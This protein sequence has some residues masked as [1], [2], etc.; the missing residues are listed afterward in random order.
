MRSI[1]VLAITIGIL[2]PAPAAELTAVLRQQHIG[3][4]VQKLD[5]PASLPK[6][7]TSGLTNRLLLR[8]S[9]RRDAQ[10]LEETAIEIA[11]RFDL[12]DEVFHVATT[13]AA[14]ESRRV[15]PSLEATLRALEDLQ[16][17]GLFV[18]PAR[19]GNEQVHVH[20]DVLLNPIDRERMDKIRQWVAENTTS[21]SSSSQSTTRTTSASSE[22]FGRIFEQY[23][24]GNDVASVWRRSLVSRPFTLTELTD[25]AR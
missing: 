3:V 6:E 23:A 25:D 8:I 7:L 5:F 15:E 12:W 14:G 16:L 4:R 9:L 22:L 13:S 20:A 19:R 18:V 21:G 24:A 10:V 11:I 2:T 17:A 1:A